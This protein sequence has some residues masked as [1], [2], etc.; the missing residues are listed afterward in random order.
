MKVDDIY[1]NA[2]NFGSYINTGVDPRTGQYSANINIITLRPNNVGNL[3]QALSLSFS[4][5]TTLNNGFGIG[6]RFSSTTLDVKTL[7]FSR[8]NGEQFKCKPLPPNGHDISFKDKKLKDLRVHKFDSNIFYVYNKNGVIEILKR[9]GSSDIAKTTAIEFPDGEAFDFIYNSR[10]ALSEIKYRATG[11]NYL[12]LNYDGINCTSVEYPDDNNITARISFDYRND[13]LITVT[14]PYDASGPIDSARFKITYKMLQ[15]IFPVI[16][17]FRTPTGYIELVSYK[18]NGHKVTDTEYIPYAAALTIQPGNG[19]PAIRKS[20]EY[21]SVHNFLGYSSG[22]TSIDSSQDNLYLVTGIYN[23]SSI[24]RVLDGTKTVSST[25]RVFNK[26]HLMT[27]EAKTQDNKRITTEI[28]YNEDLSKSFSEQPENLQ[29]PAR[30]VTH[31][32]DLQANTSREE[33]VNIVTDDWGNT[34]R[35]TETSGIQ[36]EYVYYPV[37]GDG[38]NCPADP[39]GFSR[40]LKSITQKGSLDASQK[41]ADKVTHYTYKKLPTFTGAY[42]KEYICKASETVDSKIVRTFTYINSPASKTHGLLEKVFSVQNNQST[43]TAFK[44]EYSTSTITT[45]AT[46]TGFDGAKMQS[47]NV[48]SIYTQRQLRKVD[49]NHVITDQSYDLLG[50]ITEQTIDPGT[51]KEIN[52]GYAYQY[53]GGDENSF[54][55]VMIEI[56]SQGVR[57]KTHYDGMGR[58]STIEEQDDDDTWGTSGI[59]QGTYR[60]VLAR[61]YDALG[62]LA[63]ETTNDWLW[64][65]ASN[66]LT[67]LTTPLVT[68]KTYQY[69]GWGNRYSTEYSDGRI[70]L[71]IHNPVARTITQGVKGQGMLNI[72]QNNFDQPGSIKVVYPDDTVY[73]SRTYHY[74]GF[75][76]NVTETDAEGHAT[77]IA[78]D[79]FDR[80]VKKTLPDGTLL[81]S[82]FAGFSHEELI[83]ALH[84]NGTQLGAITYDGLGRVVNDTVGG[85]KSEYVYGPQGDKPIQS[86]T[87]AHAKQNIDYLYHLGSVMSKFATETSQQNFRYHTKTGALLSASDTASQSNYSYFPSGVLQRESLSQGNKPISSGDYL[88]TMSGL[89]QRHKDSFGHDHVYSYDAQGK[90]AKTQQGPQDATF[91]YDQ[92]GR[93]VTTTTTDTTSLSQLVTKLEYDVFGREIKRTLVSDFAIQVI[94]LSYT[95]NNQINQRIT[96]IDG[97]VMKNER[98]QYDSNQ[99]LSQYQCEGEQ[100][101]VD[102]TGRV[103][104]Q[105]IYHYDQW[106]NIKQLDNTYRDG[107]ET[108]N[109]HFSK[110]D[111]TQLIRITSD[112]HQI[113]LSY[114]ANGNLI[115]DEKGQT[116]IYDQNNRLSQVKDGKGN[117]ICSYQYDALNK[118][119]TQILANSTVNR[120]HYASGKVTNA[121]LGDEAITW[122]SSDQQRLGHQSTIKGQSSYY[123]YG[124]DCNNTVVASQNERELTS[125]S[126]TPYGFRSLISSLPGLNGAQIDPVTGWYFLGN[127]YRVFNPV[128]MRFH[129]PDSWSPFGRGGVNPYTY[130]QGDPINRIDLNGHMSAGGILGII[131]GAIGIIVGIVSLGAGAAISAGLIAGG[132]IIGAIASTSAVAVT[133]TVIGLAADTIGIASTAIAEQDPKTSGILNWVSLGLGIFSFGIGATT[134]ATSLAKSARGGAQATSA[135]V[136]GSVPIEFGQVSSRASKRWDIALSAVSLGTNAV[137]LSTGIAASAVA[138]SNANAANILGWVSVGFGTVATTTGLINL[139]RSVYS[140]NNQTWELSSSSGTSEGSEAYTLS[141]FTQLEPEAVNV[142]PA[143]RAVEVNQAFRNS[144]GNLFSESSIETRNVLRGRLTI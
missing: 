137:S 48:T 110:V 104:N 119:T 24:E 132:G 7:T 94:T 115:R 61:Q 62:Q 121:Q 86:I 42:I 91:E 50:R 82:T 134:F 13:Y 81:E 44:Y 51:T 123:Q 122:L 93:L 40:L 138:D 95:K 9:I 108:I 15:G 72:Q 141:R 20:Y 97:V 34:L 71:E 49:V 140:V 77:Q 33:V 83:S 58:I 133:A 59:Y 129:S 41:V 96:S 36:K 88:Y 55:P 69:D 73:S 116:L 28:K 45:T 105:Q 92:V 21:S 113:E 118:L 53:P 3:E 144:T 2:F 35:V 90:L 68:T 139:A 16:D 120:Q 100:S 65:L 89:I 98:Y 14:V 43:V 63:K 106:G 127:G 114:D 142:H 4:P 64:D 57:R 37:N 124:N 103:L 56:D 75:G 11:K 8:A 112:K 19:Q 38:N 131:L 74:D 128:L 60:Q 143:V 135:G 67:R 84:V 52:R 99:R 101:P 79:V 107:K 70:E 102:H 130:C 85:R 1:S 66:P 25:E 27:K 76:R 39:L 136:I 78:Y 31:Y 109:Y 18:E 30:V 6:W 17:N 47:K 87:P 111:P 125:L 22:R 80:V 117:L 10:V 12:K 54:W 126:Y 29:Q 23:Y 26:F 46:V 5:L 32:T